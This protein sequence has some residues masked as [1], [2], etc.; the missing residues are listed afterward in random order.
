M[1]SI[2]YIDIGTHFAQEYNSIFGKNFSFYYIIFRRVLGYYL[3]RRGDKI[4]FNDIDLMYNWVN[5]ALVRKNSF[6]TKKIKYSE[7]LY[8]KENKFILIENSKFIDEI[9]LNEHPN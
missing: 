6:A 9:N 5:D 7:Y 1:K 2:I 3:L 4:S 8:L